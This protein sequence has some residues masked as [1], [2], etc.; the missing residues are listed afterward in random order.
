MCHT[1]QHVILGLCSKHWQIYAILTVGNSHQWYKNISSIIS[2][3]VDEK[4]S[5]FEALLV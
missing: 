5:K 1:V 4:M 2:R 3:F